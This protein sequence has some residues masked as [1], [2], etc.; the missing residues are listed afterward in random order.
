[1]RIMVRPRIAALSKVGLLC[2]AAL[3][4]SSLHAKE[5]AAERLKLAKTFAFAPV[6]SFQFMRLHSW[7]VIDDSHLLVE[8]TRKRS[9][10]LVLDRPCFGLGFQHQIGI[11]SFGRR[12]QSGFEYVVFHDDALGARVPERCR[13][14][15]ILPYD[16]QGYDKARAQRKAAA[17]LAP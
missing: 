16:L 13:I 7:R 6:D 2:F 14:Q 12:V 1:M 4:T 3:L 8:V 11:T 5:T 9:Y 15:Q 17:S 10:M